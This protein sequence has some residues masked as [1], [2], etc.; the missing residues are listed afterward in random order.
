MALFEFLRN[1]D[2]NAR[3]ANALAR[4]SLK[5]NQFGGVIGGPV[6]QNKLF[7][8]AG[9]QGAWERSDP[10]TTI[11]FVPTQAMIN[12]DFTVIAS[13]ACSGTQRNLPAP[14]VNNQILP[15]QLSQVALN[16]LK[17]VP[18]SDDPCG[19]YQ[20]GIPNPTRENQ[21][22]GKVD[23]IRSENTASSEDT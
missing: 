6:R 19:R 15:S 10:S 17:R 2:F 8:F 7:F 9:Y 21:V 14:F 13:P 3:N 22:V 5:R 18:R 12:G 4:D 23:Y 11:V 1:G 16:L 20:Y